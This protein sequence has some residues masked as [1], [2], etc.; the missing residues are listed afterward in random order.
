MPTEE[1]SYN[2]FIIIY[3]L[4]GAKISLADLF[5]NNDLKECSPNS[6][7]L[8]TSDED[9]DKLIPQLGDYAE[10]FL[11]IKELY[12]DFKLNEILN[13]KEFISQSKCDQYHQNENDLQRLKEYVKTYHSQEKYNHIFKEDSDK[14]NNFNSYINHRKDCPRDKFC[15]FLLNELPD[16]KE[17]DKYT[18]I[19]FK[20]QEG[21][22][23]TFL[24]GHQNG[25]I[26]NKIL[27]KELVAILNN[28]AKYYSFL[29]KTD[30]KGLTE[31]ERIRKIFTYQIPYY[32]GP[33][34]EG[35]KH[36]WVIRKE[37]GPV[38]ALNLEDKVD[39]KATAENF[40]KN[41]IGR[42]TYTGDSVI[43]KNS[44]LYSE[45]CVR[46]EI[47]PLKV[48]GNSLS[49]ED[50]EKLYTDLFV[51]YN[52]NVTKNTIKKY[53]QAQGIAEKDA[54]ITGVDE[55]IKSNLKSYHELKPVIEKIGEEKTEQVIVHILVFGEEK[56][57]LVEWL[58]ENCPELTKDDISYLCTLKYAGWS[59]LS[60][61][62]LTEIYHIDKKTGEAF[63]VMDMLRNY[64]LNLNQVL[65]KKY[66]FNEEA[67]KRKSINLNFDR[68]SLNRKLDS[69]WLSPMAKKS[70]KEAIAQV[71]EQI[72]FM[73]CPPAVLY[74]EGS[75]GE[76]GEKAPTTSRKETLIKLYKKN[77]LT[78]LP[79]YNELKEENAA[80]LADEK[81]YLYYSQLGF[82]AYSGTIIKKSELYS[83]N[84]LGYIYDV[85]HIFPR[86][87]I[88]DDSLNNKV[89]CLSLYNRMKMDKYP[90]AEHIRINMSDTWK[91]WKKYEFISESKFTRLI[92]KTPLTRDE[93][94]AFTNV[95]LTETRHAVVAF[96]SLISDYYPETQVITVRPSIVSDLRGYLELC[97][98]RDIND[99]HHAE[100]AYLAAV[101]GHIIEEKKKLHGYNF[102]PNTVFT[103]DTPGVWCKD[104]SSAE[105]IK[106][107]IKRCQHA[108]IHRKTKTGNG[109]LFKVSILGEGKGQTPI[110]RNKSLDYGA[111][112]ANTTSSFCIVEYIE[113]GALKR[114]I[115]PVLTKD[116]NLYNKDPEK[117]CRKILGLNEPRVLQNL[118]INSVISVN[119]L[120]YMI[121]G[122]SGNTLTGRHCY[123]LILDD[124]STRYYKRIERAVN[125]CKKAK[126]PFKVDSTRDKI[127]AEGNLKL[128]EVLKSKFEIDFYKSLFSVVVDVVKNGTEK[129][130]SLDL[131]GQVQILRSLILLLSG[132]SASVCVN[133][134]SIGGS[135][136]TGTITLSNNI[137]NKDVIVYSSSITGLYIKKT[138]YKAIPKPVSKSKEKFE[139]KIVKSSLEPLKKSA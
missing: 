105:H 79:I 93:L 40:I 23:Y 124:E 90:I 86:A 1:M 73:G 28:A 18:D 103:T 116:R 67:R 68:M 13:G 27:E 38:N 21:T 64:N 16:L 128:Y 123:P 62:F 70:V 99:I 84:S 75:K 10:T 22:F 132:K 91:K 115:A 130:K 104:G 36:Q 3:A 5:C 57:L 112:N 7:S 131:D 135:S 102:N 9:I 117:Y 12:D 88:K 134:T 55:K 63:T 136:A 110:K 83:K 125:N 25:C 8:D 107:M 52:S 139:K 74:V 59:A 106:N 31:I 54:D 42:C 98:C 65:S 44:L 118:P 43:P 121:S 47:N 17:N 71:N 85:D 113:K 126:V 60:R 94:A 133:L 14:I 96:S 129:F 26:P 19:C 34:G 100:D 11:A 61:E 101:T 35:A 97:K 29:N 120:K 137:T 114:I 39:L 138:Y 49:H 95:Q 87:K 109:S 51:N 32:C 48:N 41:L 6:T 92:R 77:K 2:P 81:L 82:C 119:G 76:M 20:I 66:S 111:Y 53:L 127:T 37:S 80:S 78:K 46:N 69:F 72:K 30:E 50:M 15:A 45:Y 89:L 33:F 56:H 122:R 108:N 24:N 58:Y 4:T